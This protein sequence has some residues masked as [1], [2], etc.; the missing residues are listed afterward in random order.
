MKT[1][2]EYLN[3]IRGKGVACVS[4]NNNMKK[5]YAENMKHRTLKAKVY[6]YEKN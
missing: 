4:L 1:E 3:V 5:Y 2:F 6:R